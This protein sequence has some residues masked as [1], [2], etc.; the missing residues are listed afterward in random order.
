VCVCERERERERDRQASYVSS[1]PTHHNLLNQIQHPILAHIAHKQGQ[2]IR[3]APNQFPRHL[4]TGAWIQ[5]LLKP[6]F[7]CLHSPLRQ[8]STSL[9]LLSQFNLLAH[10][11]PSLP[12]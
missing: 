12:V 4:E 7:A 6:T 2:E 8:L 9:P 10:Q 1:V 11:V 5:T 3:L